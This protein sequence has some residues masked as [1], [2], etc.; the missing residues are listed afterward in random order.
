MSHKHKNIFNFK[1]MYRISNYA[2]NVY[3]FGENINKKKNTLHGK[4]L[5][6]HIFSDINFL[7]FIKNLNFMVIWI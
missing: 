5:S 6:L 4:I 7:T 1:K 3:K 2:H